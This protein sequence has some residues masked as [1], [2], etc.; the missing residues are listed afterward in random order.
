MLI[1]ERKFVLYYKLQQFTQKKKS[2]KHRGSLVQPKKTS[3]QIDTDNIKSIRKYWPTKPASVTEYTK[4][5]CNHIKSLV[6]ENL[7]T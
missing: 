2:K 4:N 1:L 6:Q 3:S 5:S 7:K